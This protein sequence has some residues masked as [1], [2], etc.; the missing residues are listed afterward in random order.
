[1]CPEKREVLAMGSVAFT[2]MD[3]QDLWNPLRRPNNQGFFPIGA[4]GLACGAVVFLRE[5]TGGRVLLV[6]KA[7]RPGYE[8]SGLWALPGG[9]LRS[10]DSHVEQGLEED[11]EEAGNRYVHIRTL[12]ETGVALA[13]PEI[14]AVK[15]LFPPP[16]TRYK[17][18]GKVR[19][20]LVLPFTH[21]PLPS[22]VEP[23][24]A[25]CPSIAAASWCDP[26]KCWE[27]IA[28]ANQLL[29]AHHLWAE[30][31]V[32]QRKEVLPAL[33]AAREKLTKWAQEVSFEPPA[34][35]F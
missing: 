33:E 1:M 5:E 20:T 28:P 26:I 27:E 12:Q 29:L 6:Q 10:V 3:Q 31:T 14:R 8:F 30:W 34:L 19:H 23:L 13:Q 25:T 16:V 7:E 32:G 22:R 9:M 35:P 11:L 18:K 21:P 17:A 4:H 15:T 24:I 2:A